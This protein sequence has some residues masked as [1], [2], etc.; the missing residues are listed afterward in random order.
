MVIFTSSFDS[1]VGKNGGKQPYESLKGLFPQ[2]DLDQA[3]KDPFW[4]DQ[5]LKGHLE[6]NVRIP[7]FFV[8]DKERL[9]DIIYR[10]RTEP[11]AGESPRWR[12]VIR[13]HVEKALRWNTQGV[14]QNQRLSRY[15]YT[16]LPEFTGPPTL[17]LAD[18][19]HIAAVHRHLDGL[20]NNVHTGMWVQPI[21]F[22]P[23]EREGGKI[24]IEGTTL[25]DSHGYLLKDANRD[26]DLDFIKRL[27]NVR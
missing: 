12:E 13:D 1:Y 26:A 19:A 20:T 27:A 5:L 18:A 16:L 11:N 8:Q 4:A 10:A 7:K 21:R 9:N 3:M 14:D 24:K 23:P 6:Q 17:E 25:Q 15:A 22:T 2:H